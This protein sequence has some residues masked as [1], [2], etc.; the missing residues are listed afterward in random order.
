ML[1]ASDFAA[2]LAS[3]ATDNDGLPGVA[4]EC[5]AVETSPTAAAFYAYGWDG[6]AFL[7]SVTRVPGGHPQ[8]R[9]AEAEQRRPS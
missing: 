3:A 5:S 1:N 4:E 8:A 7:V 2:A 9:A 6:E